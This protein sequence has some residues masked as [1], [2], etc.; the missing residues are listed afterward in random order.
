VIVSSAAFKCGGSYPSG[1]KYQLT[2]GLVGRSAPIDLGGYP[3]NT[4]GSF[5]ASVPI[6][7]NASPGEAYIV[8]RGSPFDEC[9]DTNHGSCAGYGVGLTI[10]PGSS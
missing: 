3:V 2:L 5:E 9:N 4:D 1:K 10:L 6:P 8:I 7:V